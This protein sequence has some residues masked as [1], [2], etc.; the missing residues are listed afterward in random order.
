MPVFLRILDTISTPLP[1][2]FNFLMNSKKTVKNPSRTLLIRAF[3]ADAELQ[4]L[5]SSY[6]V[7]CIKQGREYHLQLAFW[8]STS[9]W[10]MTLMKDRRVNDEDIIDRFISDISDVI[11]LSK[12]SEAQIA[13]YMILSVLGSV[14]RLSSEVL[15]ASMKSVVF[16]WTSDASKS[17][18]ACITQLAKG[19]EDE[20]AFDKSIWT[21]LNKDFIISELIGLG[22]EY[23]V[24]KFTTLFLLSILT[25]K[26]WALLNKIPKILTEIPITDSQLQLVVEATLVTVKGSEFTADLRP[27]FSALFKHLLQTEEH[28]RIVQSALE[29]QNVSFEAL[30]LLLQTSLQSNL[31]SKSLANDSEIEDAERAL[32]TASSV[33]LQLQELKECEIDSFLDSHYNEEFERRGTLFSAAIDRIPDSESLASILKLKPSQIPSFLARIWTGVYPSLVRA[34]ALKLF[35]NHASSNPCDYQGLV[36]LLFVALFDSAERVRMLSINCLKTINSTYNKLPKDFEVWGLHDIFGPVE[37][38][39]DVK[40]MSIEHVKT[41]LS[42]T[43]FQNA[44]EI[45]LNTT[46]ILTVLQSFLSSEEKNTKRV[47]SEFF[48]A[49]T[50][51]V[52]YCKIPSSK[53]SLLRLVNVSSKTRSKYLSPLLKTWFENRS[54]YI[55]LS[56]ASNFPM[57]SLEAEVFGILSA[58][59]RNLGINFLE[60]GIKSGIP[61]I[62]EKVT[63][64]IVELWSGFRQ[65]T[66]IQLFKLLVDHTLDDS[67]F[68]D[69]S[70][71]FGSIVISASVFESILAECTLESSTNASTASSSSVAKRR[72][73]SSGAAKQRLQTGEMAQVAERHLKRTTLVLEILEKNKPSGN[74]HLLSLLFTILSEILS[75]GA[76]SNLPV[77]YT[78]QVLANCMIHLVNDLKS[79]PNIK[80]DSS[81]MRIDILV[82][83]IRTSGSQQ[84][85][86]RFLLLVANMA[87]IASDIVL[88]SV[89]PIF[90]F[91]GANTIRQDD[92]FSAYVIQQTITQVIPALLSDKTQNK[93]EDIDFLFLSFVAAFSHI[94]RHRRIRLYSS[95]VKTLGSDTLYRIVFILAEK[96]HEA[97]L[98]RKNSEAKSLWQFSDAFIRGFPVV[99]Q[100]VMIEK[101]L[102]FLNLIPFTEPTAEERKERSLSFFKRQIFHSINTFNTPAL[103]TLRSNL[104]EYLSLVISNEQTS[105][106][107]IDPLRISI[108]RLFHEKSLAEMHPVVQKSAEQSISLVLQSLINLQAL[109]TSS[110][111]SE[112]IRILTSSYYRLLDSVLELLPIQVFVHIFRQILLNS[113]DDKIRRNALALVRSKFEMEAYINDDANEAARDAFNSI[114]QLIATTETEELLQMSFDALDRI[115]AKYWEQFDPKELIKL[116]DITVGPKGLQHSE[117]DTV[118]AAVGVISSVCSA[119]G[120]RSIGH[121]SKIIPVLFA[122]FE[123][124]VEKNTI[125]SEDDAR[126]IQVS[127]FALTANLVQ[128]LPAFMTSSLAKILKLVFIS[129]VDV[130]TRFRVLESLSQHIDPKKLLKAYTETWSFAVN[131]NWDS[132]NLFIVSFDNLVG[133][134]ERKVVSSLANSL[135]GFL[136]SAFEARTLGPEKYDGNTYN[137]IEMGLIKSGLQIVMK[138]NDKTFRPLFVRMVR[139]AIDGENSSAE[140]DEIQRRVI[141][142]KFASKMFGSLK[143]IV[144]SYYGYL[145]DAT[146]DIL[147]EYTDAEMGKKLSGNKAA[148][149]LRTAIFSSLA[150]CF[151]YDREEF[152]QASARFDK[153]S[154]SLL[155]QYSTIDLNQ[156]KSLV[157][158]VVAL[159][160]TVNAQ[161]QYKLIN[162]GIIK[163]LKESCSV[164]EKIWGIRTLK[165]LYAKLGEEWV[166]MLNPLVPIIAE[167]LE[168]D[169]ESVVNEV[170]K[171]LA[172]VVEDVIGEPL[173]RYLT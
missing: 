50:S 46:K 1:P 160:E 137:R 74:T 98:K 112:P 26:S 93:E 40:W 118:V 83:C 9:I 145:V 18:L 161:E 43:V 34:H 96:Y 165:N 45:S 70:D 142:F 82:S 20:V 95:L 167:L 22:R 77:D 84:V 141:F 91:M 67:S 110:N 133:S 139:W 150:V 164:N 117:I 153:I 132:I 140:F 33:E 111:T 65:E 35:Q 123:E 147:D 109:K 99:D 126:M 21:A 60:L 66:Q 49:L 73:R 136:L 19:F 27:Q 152:W 80:L 156:G 166:P 78:Q 47:G 28:E 55:K 81:S 97:K 100:V 92:E 54:E 57:A 114:V 143:S 10:T 94:P 53:T 168:D 41:L 32:S 120:A 157:K 72:R 48:S 8:S 29:T 124:S 106:S 2:V 134:V 169:D 87:P 131:E 24:T 113:P 76:D 125:I 4:R 171:N 69:S 158:A 88:H 71:I 44:E 104:I 90:T 3:A 144:T 128:R 31:L 61:S 51:Q 15:N 154:T 103:F 79:Q 115:V 52:I 85:Q 159:A 13:S 155:E 6:I 36:P 59:E 119:I 58:G 163:H 7:D 42:D 39:S 5:V 129:T 30:E 101:Y 56:R 14:T 68:F 17:G 37:K 86:N 107:E 170:T 130:D 12:H 162:D 75:L 64:K 11:P 116:L 122:K 38:S 127:T 62:G 146:C 121:F 25:H 172:P 149:V 108:G 135:I 148:N 173:D 151:Q 23:N 16:N 63:Q 138:L 102:E 105:N 89:M